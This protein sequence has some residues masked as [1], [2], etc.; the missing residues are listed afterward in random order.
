MYCLSILTI[1]PRPRPSEVR[2]NNGDN[3]PPSSLNHKPKR[4]FIL[5]RRENELARPGEVTCDVCTG[6]MARKALKSCLVC[7]VS[8]C[9]DHLELHGRKSRL[10]G[11]KLVEPVEN[12]DDRACLEHGRPLELYCRETGRCICAL[13]VEDGQEV[14]SVEMEWEDKKVTKSFGR[15]HVFEF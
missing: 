9:R 13:C 15:P 8:Y 11:H 4:I 5:S 7:L 2:R 12:L 1:A 6:P 10:R 14:V 3:T